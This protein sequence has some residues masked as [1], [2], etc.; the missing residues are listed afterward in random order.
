MSEQRQRNLDEL[1][2]EIAEVKRLIMQEGALM[3]KKLQAIQDAQPPRI[4]INQHVSEEVLREQMFQ[5]LKSAKRR[6]KP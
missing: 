5:S 4:V 2:S 6:G 3:M 1:M